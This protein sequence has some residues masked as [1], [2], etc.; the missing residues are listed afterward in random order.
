VGSVITIK[1]HKIFINEPGLYEILLK[2][3]KPLAKIFTYK[4]LTEIIVPLGRIRSGQ[5]PELCLKLE[6]KENI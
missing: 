3:T 6:K 5:S 4:F 1:P 2:S